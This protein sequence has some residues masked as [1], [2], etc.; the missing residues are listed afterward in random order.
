MSDAASPDA[1]SLTGSPTAR[2]LDGPILPTLMALAL[3][4]LVMVAAQLGASAAEAY[5]VGRLGTEALAGVA[6]V[7]PLF[8]LMQM[9]SAGAMGG[10]ISSAVARALGAGRRD[11]AEAFA[12]HAL[13]I[14]LGLGAVFTVAA[15]LG[16][17]VLYRAM[18][19]SGAPLAA[20]LAYSNVVFGGA[21]LSWLMNSLASVLR[22][23]GNMAV[24]AGML[25]GVAAGSIALAPLFMFGLGPLPGL[26]VAGA[27]AALVACYGFGAAFFAWYLVTGRGGL[28]LHLS[29]ARLSLHRLGEIL[30]V[31]LPAVVH[32]MLIN[33]SVVA[34]TGYVGAFGTAALAGYGLGARLEYLQIP[35]VFGF[36]A[37]LVAMVGTNVGAG[38][39][40]RARRVVLTGG[41]AGFFTTGA[42]GL[43]VALAPDLWTGLFSADPAV[44][45]AG[46]L[47]LQ[48]AGW[49]YG[50]LGLGMSLYF[51]A[52]GAG[53]MLWPLVAGSARLAILA[54]GGYAV[55]TL[56]GG[57]LA[58]LFVVIVLGLIAFGMIN[59]AGALAIFPIPRGGSVST[60]PRSENQ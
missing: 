34:V 17:P 57:T 4:N 23:T 53:N 41:L 32:A 38:R 50:F 52:Q 60:D 18:G 43:A 13:V 8:M 33:L 45:A 46:A 24:S 22:G 6:L 29:G 48:R 54:G 47:Y 37:A 44:C 12:L 19:G 49:V 10:G 35:I 14:A 11:E 21:V 15:L 16:G 59:L 27:A 56:L 42:I 31:G 40:A 26:G 55:V 3:P 51:A 28:R 39:H 9:M 30:R 36:G 7:L 1:A 58:S 20:A 5:Y 25:I 2:L